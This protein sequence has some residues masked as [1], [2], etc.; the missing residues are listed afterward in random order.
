LIQA[1]QSARVAASAKYRIRN[2]LQT[3]VDYITKG[4]YAAAP[5]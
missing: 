1:K 3:L 2:A 4:E 5:C